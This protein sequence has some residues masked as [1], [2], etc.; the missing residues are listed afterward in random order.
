ME[1]LK[2]GT[3][4]E[5]TITEWGLIG[6]TRRFNHLALAYKEAGFCT[7]TGII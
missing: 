5:G 7:G 4:L 1:C 3:I 6:H 2:F